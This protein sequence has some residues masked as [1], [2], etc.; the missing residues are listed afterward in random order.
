MTQDTQQ[1]IKDLVHNDR[2]FLFMK[3]T[4][5]Q[6]MCGFSARVVSTLDSVVPEYG[7]FNVLE[8][9][10]VREGIKDYANWPTIP[11]LYIDGEF[12][13]GCDIVLEMFNKGELHEMLG[14]DA[15]DRTAPKISISEK[16]AEAIAQGLQGQPGD[17]HM[18]ISPDWEHQFYIQPATP[19]SIK[20][21]ISTD[22]TSDDGIAF[23]VHFDLASA[24]RADGLS[25]DWEDSL[26]GTGLRIDNP[27][28]PPPVQPIEPQELAD[29]LEQDNCRLY[30]TRPAEDREKARIEQ[31][32]PLTKETMAEIAKLPKDTPLVFHCHHGSSSIASAQH[33]RKQGFTNVYNLTG[34]I[35]AWSQQV[36]SSVP[37]Y[38]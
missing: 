17:L 33:F 2:V 1:R 22:G 28:A 5:K 18:T 38:S 9:E 37:R 27:N 12:V 29:R 21:E 30:D 34:G 19:H 16:A 15:P 31:A 35:D 14:Q 20:A 11:Q 8:D 10:T 36:D 24:G 4:R 32:E 6:P 25:I 26:Q 13:G 3:G 7:T 23:P